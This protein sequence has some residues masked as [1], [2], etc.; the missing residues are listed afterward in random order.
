MSTRHRLQQGTAAWFEMVG[1]MMAQ[2]ASR[3]GLPPDLTLSLVE[4]YTDGVEL[5]PGLRQGIRF[6]IQDGA[7]SFRAGVKP[8]ERGDITVEVTAQ[9]ARD[10]NRLSSADP[11][12]A[13]AR[14]RFTDNGD[15]RIEGDAARLGSWLEA[16]HDP[17]VERTA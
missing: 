1:A 11:R 9:A 15:Y 6:D 7:P 2:A 8:G 14:Q 4:R 3:A 17:I 5:S 16:V 12:Y 13:Q 10:L